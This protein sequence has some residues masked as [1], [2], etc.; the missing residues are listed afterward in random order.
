MLK[1]W[2]LPTLSV[3]MSLCIHENVMAQRN[4][5]AEALRDAVSQVRGA[6][7]P[8]GIPRS[9]AL[10]GLAMDL[11]ELE[12]RR[13]EFPISDEDLDILRRFADTLDEVK[14]Q[15]GASSENVL[16]RA[17]D[18]VL[19]NGGSGRAFYETIAGL[20]STLAQSI[21]SSYAR[22]TRNLSGPGRASVERF[23]RDVVIPHSTSI[24]IDYQSLALQYPEA[25]TEQA[26]F[27]CGVLKGRPEDVRTLLEANRRLVEEKL[28][29]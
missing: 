18:V 23:L 17:C 6:E 9:A 20:N 25:I 5:P 29:D 4:V 12:R 28:G 27:N 19:D 1:Q 13:N 22:A 10:E 15:E 7:D 11:D 16:R 2:M 24:E 8:T 3:A 26:R 14:R 21:V